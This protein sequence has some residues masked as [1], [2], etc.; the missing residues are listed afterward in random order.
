MQYKIQTTFCILFTIFLLSCQENK[1]PC[2]LSEGTLK[3]LNKLDSLLSIQ[4]HVYR[5]N[6]W[7]KNNYNE[8]SVMDAKNETYR[9]TL[10]TSFDGSEVY[11]IEK[12]D[13]KY[14]AIIKVFAYGDTI[15]KYNEFEIS[16]EVWN[17]ISESLNNLD[18]WTYTSSIDRKGLDGS[19]WI[20]EGYK[21]IKDKCTLRKYHSINRWSP[22]DTTFISMCALF[23]KLK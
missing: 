15:G 14:K 22:N 10:E 3:D 4:K 19:S 9:F 8:P 12:K 2:S 20:L 23:D 1:N 7:M 13:N 16:K 6:A 21:P 5:H 11:R 18:F 17:S